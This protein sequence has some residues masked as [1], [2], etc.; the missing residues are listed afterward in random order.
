MEIVK[1]LVKEWKDLVELLAALASI[2]LVY[3]SVMLTCISRQTYRRDAPKLYLSLS[4]Y[5][6]ANDLADSPL[7]LRVT[8]ANIGYRNSILR[9][10]TI[11]G[12]DLF[13][14]LLTMNLFGQG[15]SDE[16]SLERKRL[17]PG[18]S[19]Q[20]ELGIDT[21]QVK[22]LKNSKHISVVEINGEEHKLSR[23]DRRQLKDDLKKNTDKNKRSMT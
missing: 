14:E 20:S 1:E 9:H 16:Y 3:T 18:E 7:N 19:W 6:F 2:L 13:E 12:K 5:K 15:S 23:K 8:V 22:K 11:D 4:V 10:I 17:K 21:S